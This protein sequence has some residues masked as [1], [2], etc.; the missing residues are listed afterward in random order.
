[1]GYELYRL[2][3]TRTQRKKRKTKKVAAG[4]LF[5]DIEEE[6][7]EK[8]MLDGKNLTSTVLTV[9]WKFAN[10]PDSFSLYTI[11]QCKSKMQ[12]IFNLIYEIVYPC[13]HYYNF[14]INMIM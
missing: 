8:L 3:A 7:K 4:P 11:Y 5:I 10:C 9:F 6:D 13:R 1:M 12:S 2:L 14:C